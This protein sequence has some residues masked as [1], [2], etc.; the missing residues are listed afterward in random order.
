[1]DH[2]TLSRKIYTHTHTLFPCGPGPDRL[3][4][5]P[6]ERRI[7]N[8]KKKKKKKRPLSL[9]ALYRCDYYRLMS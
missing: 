8:Y 7:G 3:I 5:E 6:S 1:M 2:A 9:N 4:T